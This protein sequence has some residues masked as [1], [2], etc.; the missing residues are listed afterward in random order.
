MG[1]RLDVEPAPL[2]D[3]VFVAD[4]AAK[5][6]K[7]GFAQRGCWDEVEICA[8]SELLSSFDKQSWRELKDDDF[9]V[10]VP[11]AGVALL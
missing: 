3:L 4:H 1:D 10:P 9:I 8:V 2:I 6:F 11:T 5:G 7:D